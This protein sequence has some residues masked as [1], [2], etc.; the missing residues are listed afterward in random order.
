MLG[1]V[2]VTVAAFESDDTL[3]P[4]LERW[5]PGQL[6]EVRSRIDEG[7]QW[8]VDVLEKENSVHSLEFVVDYT[9]LD[10]PVA[11]RY[12]PI[13]QSSDDEHLWIDDFLDAVGANSTSDYLTDLEAFNHRQRLE[14]NTNWAFTILVVNNNTDP[15]G[16]FADGRRAYAHGGGPHTVV[17]SLS[18][19]MTVAHEVGHIFYSLDE[20]AGADHDFYDKRGYY[21]SQNT[22]AAEQRPSSAGAQNDS[23]MAR[24]IDGGEALRTNAFV[25]KSTDRAALEMIGWR[26]SDAVGRRHL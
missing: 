22:N 14:H 12:E 10:S 24:D 6:E 20:Y 26:D 17:R 3:D 4:N 25:S 9:F 11:T 13:S 7:L 8:W 2:H 1:T 21:N 23:I 15:D 16:N 5:T 19:A 18:P